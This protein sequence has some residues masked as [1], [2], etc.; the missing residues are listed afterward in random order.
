MTRV[1]VVGGGVIGL[2]TA[3]ECARAGAE[4]VVFERA[5]LPHG[6]A[7]SYDAQRVVRALHPGDPAATEDA[8]AAQRYWAELD[9]LLGT[10]LYRPTGAL[11]VRR[12]DALAED[13]AQLAAAGIPALALRQRA[14]GERFPQLRVQAGYGAV[15]EAGAGVVRADRVLAAMVGWLRLNPLARLRL[16]RRVVDVDAA[17]GAVRLAG[18]SVLE[19]DAIVVTAGPW[20]RELLPARVAAELALYRQSVLYCG[21]P[22][23]DRSAWARMPAASLGTAAGAWLVPPAAGP[24]LTLSAHSACREV[25]ALTDHV[26]PEP[27]RN[28]LVELFGRLI[29]GLRASWVSDCRDGYYLADRATGGP[30]LVG[31][32][33]GAGWAYAACGGASFKFAPLIARSLAARALNGARTPLAA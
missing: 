5:E 7:T 8:V 4:V 3:V 6:R 11:T 9:E 13:V 22:A 29:P 31:L 21:V 15:L 24:L 20:S 30:R 33:G 2:L 19:A 25:A 32:P 18:G 10:R 28:H 23:T 26:T 16:H 12:E 1:V 17:A 27:W 14:L